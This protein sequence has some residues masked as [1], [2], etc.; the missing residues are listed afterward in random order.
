MLVFFISIQHL[1]QKINIFLFKVALLVVIFLII[2]INLFF[3]IQFYNP[4]FV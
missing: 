3:A 4:F 1:K 2:S